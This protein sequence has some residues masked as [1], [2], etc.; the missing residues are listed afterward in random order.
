MPCSTD[1][2]YQV[3][4]GK[5][6]NCPI[7]LSGRTG[8]APLP[9]IRLSLVLIAP[10]SRAVLA[11]KGIQPEAT[12]HH[13][14]SQVE[15]NK[16]NLGSKIVLSSVI[17]WS[18][19][20]GLLS[21]SMARGQADKPSAA[22]SPQG[23]APAD[24][25]AY[26]LVPGDVIELRMFYNPDLNEEQVQIRPDGRISLQLIGE[27]QIAGKTIQEAVTM[28]EE[29][30]VKDVRSPK[31]M[32]QVRSFAAQKVYVTGEV[33]RP[34]LINLPGPLTVFEAIS[35]AGGK[36]HMGDNNLVVLIRKGSDGKPQAKRLFLHKGRELTTDAAT[37]LRPF[38]VI[39]VP[40]SKV[41]H[42]DRWVDQH[43]RQ[44]IPVNT[45]AGFSYL[46]TSQ[47]GIV[48]P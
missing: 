3:L 1:T 23:L 38:D 20:G 29:R 5:R 21:T 44:M 46:L 11:L 48:V 15:M 22:G 4:P 18:E 12:E 9:N 31:L 35:E 32:I 6:V 33:V 26:R 42:V 30:Y 25:Q 41:A 39:M 7:D 47:G 36:T 14:V 10:Q 45:N 19:T 16:M 43:I 8:Y 24:D 27:V 37:L 17:L 28:L 2:L 13:A 34:G 40:E